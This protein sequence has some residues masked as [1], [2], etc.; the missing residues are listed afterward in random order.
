MIV[1]SKEACFK[2]CLLSH[3][4][5]NKFEN[6]WKL[7]FSYFLTASWLK[8]RQKKNGKANLADLEVA[9]IRLKKATKSHS[10]LFVLLLKSCQM[11]GELCGVIT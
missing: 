3:W 8:K 1:R 7:V 9:F 10:K 6:R 5:R 2:G 11:W 4:T